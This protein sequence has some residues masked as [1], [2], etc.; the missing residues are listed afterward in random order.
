MNTGISTQIFEQFWLTIF[1]LLPLVLIS[2]VV[3]TGTKYSPTLF[4]VIFGLTMGYALVA[5]DVSEPGL[6]DFKVVEHVGR[7]LVIALTP[8]FFIGGQEIRKTFGKLHIEHTELVE[9]NDTIATIGT[10]MTHFYY[11][12][13]ALLLLV[14]LDTAVRAIVGNDPLSFYPLL[15]YICLIGSTIIVENKTIKGD[16]KH[17]IRQGFFETATILVI[18]II[19]YGLSSWVQPFFTLP[20][21]F[22][23]M[24]I[25]CPLGM[26]FYKWKHGPTIKA[27]MFAGVP[28]VLAGNFIVGGSRIST[29]LSD[30]S[31]SVMLPII[32]YGFF[33]QLFWMFGGISILILFAKTTDVRNIAPAM[34]GALSHAGIIGACTA[35]DLGALARIR[36]PIM[37][38]MPYLANLLVFPLLA[39]SNN[40]GELFLI[41][42]VIILVIGIVL[43]ISAVVS[44]RTVELTANDEHKDSKEV[45]SLMRFA[46]GWQITAV[47][48][49][50][51]LLSVLSM[52]FSY[53]VAAVTSS[54]SHFG[55]FAAAQAGLFGEEIALLLPF[56]FAMPFLVYPFVF[57]IFGIAMNNE[58]HMPKRPVF[59]L[60]IIGVIG[61][62]LA[63][64]LI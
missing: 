19:T 46:L 4:I 42:A 44:L 26:I 25:A 22:F 10:T 47:F 56:M 31:L 39:S 57:Y 27:M 50:F 49:G 2:R 54:L 24:L 13:R 6:P 40:L 38:N 3:V 23:A 16:K 8:A 63:F 55:L 14:G 18:L 45:K 59:V 17:Y 41:P 20:Q 51:V 1:C 52:N 7:G 60:T 5:S 64:V 15:S 36:T 29:A 9:N 43:T 48:G 37:I 12:V 21:G 30:G 11:I 32:S 58:G 35:G 53:S 34:A 62:A 61:A 33:G 28:I